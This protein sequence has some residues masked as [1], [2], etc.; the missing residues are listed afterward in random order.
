M[1][2]EIYRQID[3]YDKKTEHL[4]KELKIEIFDIELM[5]SRFDIPMDDP[6]MYNQYEIDQSKKDLFPE[7]DFDFEKYDYFLAC[8]SVG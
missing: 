6:L 3:A 8:Y 5:K 1:I 7:I 2:S 4:A